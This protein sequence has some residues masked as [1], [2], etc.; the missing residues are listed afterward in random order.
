MIV[1]ASEAI[2]LRGESIDDNTQVKI[3]SIFY[4]ILLKTFYWYNTFFIEVKVRKYK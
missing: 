1:V 2:L 3:Q 4:S